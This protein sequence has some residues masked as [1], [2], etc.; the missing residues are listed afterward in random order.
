MLMLT[1]LSGARTGFMFMVHDTDESQ[2]LT[3]LNRLVLESTAE[4]SYVSAMQL[5]EFGVTL[6]FAVPPKARKSR[7]PKSEPRP[8]HRRGSFA[9]K[10]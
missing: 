4:G 3:S 1:K 8:W 9:D 5:P 10:D 2:D 7:W 6:N